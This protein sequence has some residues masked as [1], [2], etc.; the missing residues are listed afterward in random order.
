MTEESEINFREIT[1]ENWW[2]NIIE[3]FIIREVGNLRSNSK[4]FDWWNFQITR[5]S[6]RNIDPFIKN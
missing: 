5:I 4:D 2:A 6:Q 3:K 1:S